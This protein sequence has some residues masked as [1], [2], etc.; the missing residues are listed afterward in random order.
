MAEQRGGASRQ[1]DP[2][3]LVMEFQHAYRLLDPG[4]DDVH[5][6]RV[7]VTDAGG[8]QV[9]LLGISRCRPW[10]VGNFS[11]RLRDESPLLAVIASELLTPDGD[12]NVRFDGA[13]EMAVG[14]FLVIEHLDLAAPYDTPLVA[15]AVVASAA[16]RLAGD[17]G[18]I[19]I[20][21]S[22]FVLEGGK[23]LDEAGALLQAFEFSDR[24][25]LIDT[26]LAA[27]EEA[28]RQVRERLGRRRVERWEEGPDEEVDEDNWQLSA[29]T[30]TV[31]QA[32]LEDLSQQAWEEV[33]ALDDEP[34]ARGAAGL[35]AELPPLTFHRP[36]AW[37][38]HM[39]RA[40][41]DLCA[42]L[43]AGKT[44]YP[45]C[46]GE[47]MALHLAIRQAKTLLRDRPNRI[48][49]LVHELPVSE[50]DFDWEACLDLLFEDH[51]VLLLFD[52]SLDGVDDADSEISQKLGTVN[53]NPDDWFEP[54]GEER[55]PQRGFRHE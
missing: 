23:L 5:H 19:V 29:R 42:D 26:A 2:S 4:T 24:L 17:C 6:W 39:A 52:R 7:S 18:T 21:R 32:A 33:V 40:F 46:T 15:A 54:F 22:A 48:T 3:G 14:D 30:A 44:P 1:A 11:D 9:G 55:D 27:S 51:D 35:F 49:D 43:D 13:V 45:R 8:G 37:R 47:E 38:K 25:R 50:D 36:R 53:L 31:L 10:G 41:D 20:P 28:S 34:L 16:D 12:P